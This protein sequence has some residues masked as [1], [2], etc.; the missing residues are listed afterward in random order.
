MASLRYLP[1]EKLLAIRFPEQPPEAPDDTA[2]GSSGA[3]RRARALERALAGRNDEARALLVAGGTPLDRKYLAD[4]AALEGAPEEAERLFLATLADDPCDV[5]VLSWL[6]HRCDETPSPQIAAWFRSAAAENARAA[7]VQ[8]VKETP[9]RP[10]LWRALATFH[11]LRGA[12]VSAQRCAER[13]TV[14]EEAAERRGRAVGRALAAA[15]YHFAAK[16]KG[17]M[18]EVWAGRRPVERGRGG[19]LDE[20]LGNLGPEMVQDAKSTFLS[21]REY[22]R[23]R[24]P[25]LTRDVLDYSYTYKVTKEDEPSGGRSA[26]LPTALAFLSVFLDRP[27]P[28][29]VASSG[30]LVA[31]AHDVLVVKGVGEAE[32]KLR[33]AYNRNLRMLLLP[34][35]NRRD[36]RASPVVPP[37]VCGEIVH[38]VADLDEAA[39]LVFGQEIWGTEDG[40]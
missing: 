19:F 36:L 3:P 14:L 27:L 34:R 22:A 24:F 40:R 8:A 31:D 6:L 11:A 17:L 35:D 39:T 30:V 20:V 32:H 21:V 29:D 9:L 5:R 38:Y 26:G 23:A 10:S 28:Q 2:D 7:L 25:H 12:D 33:G 15:V 16:P 18:H 37:A 13:A 1:L 4:L